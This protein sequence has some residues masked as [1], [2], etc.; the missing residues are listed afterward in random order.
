MTEPIQR[1]EDLRVEP[2]Y[3]VGQVLWSS[4]HAAATEFRVWDDLAAAG[5]LSVGPGRYAL[6]GP[7]AAMVEHLRSTAL[8]IGHQLGYELWCLPKL[9]PVSVLQKFGCVEAWPDY[10]LRVIPF[11]KKLSDQECTIA[12]DEDQY[13]L[14]PVQCAA[15]Y[16]AL[17][18]QPTSELPTIKAIDISG[19]TYRNEFRS[20]LEGTIKSVEFLRA[21]YVFAG[22]A[23]VREAR[24]D[25]L[26]KYFALCETNRLKWRV[27][28]GKGCYL[29]P[30]EADRSAQRDAVDI[31]DIPVLDIEIYSQ[32]LGKW[33]EVAGASHLHASKLIRFGV[34]AGAEYESGC[35]GVGL[36]RLAGLLLEYHGT[37]IVDSP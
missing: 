14:E 26:E 3:E 4:S 5:A 8:G 30:T 37:D 35:F 29:H 33:I 18:S 13:C 15:F 23:T 9:V 22:R 6:R 20:E 31:L 27:V 28:V 12:A 2:P 16:E 1:L 19:Y 36:T 32:S 17:G 7:F 11:G 34:N 24:A 21:E 25:L 10:L